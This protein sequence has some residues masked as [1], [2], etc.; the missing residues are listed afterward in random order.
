VK[1][2]VLVSI[3]AMM[4]AAT[5][6]SR[7]QTYEFNGTQYDDGATA[8]E[9]ELTNVKGGTYRLSENR[10]RIVLIYFGYTFC[11]DICPGTLAQARQMFDL[12]GEQAEMVE[13]LFVTVD[14]E[15]DTPEVMSA[16]VSA[17]H[18]RI[19]GLTGSPDELVQVFDAYGI[20][21]EKEPLPESAVGYVMN[22]T[23]R[24]LLVDQAGRLRLSYPFGTIAEDMAEDIRHLWSDGR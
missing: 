4:L 17:F 7:C 9:I 15:R 18:P 2:T 19:V 21:A 10:G 11:P 3:A 14:P 23:T 12:L 8:P 1:R 16:Y 5:V 22:H 24:V 20:V 13:F 6:L